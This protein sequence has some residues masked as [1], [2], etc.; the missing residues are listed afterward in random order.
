MSKFNRKINKREKRIATRLDLLEYEY[1]LKLCEKM[2]LSQSELIRS[3]IFNYHLKRPIKLSK[4]QHQD[5]IE[6]KNVLINRM[7][8]SANY[9]TNSD[10]EFKVEIRKAI[11]EIKNYLKTKGL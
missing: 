3:A 11:D 6:L 4:E 1:L 7:Q 5:I 10:P 8:R 2:N 9:F